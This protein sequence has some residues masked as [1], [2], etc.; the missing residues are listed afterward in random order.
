MSS[1]I[2]DEGHSYEALRKC[3][4]A[5]IEEN[6]MCTSQDIKTPLARLENVS[7]RYS[8]VSALEGLNLSVHAGEIL[9]LLGPNGAGKTT[10]VSLLLNLIAADSGTVSLFGQDPQELSARQRIGVMLQSAE[11]PETLRVS[12]LL[13]LT[14]SYYP[15]KRALTEVC[16][17]AGIADLLPRFY[18]K[19]SGGQQRRVQFALAIC[20]KVEILFLDE[21]TVG[22]DIEAR[23]ALWASLRKLI[24]EG[25]AIV[26][27]THYLEEA[28]ALADRVIVIA[29]GAVIA[30]GSVDDIRARVSQRRIRCVSA[31]DIEE[32]KLWPA[33][34]SV[35]RDGETLHIQT[36]DAEAVARRLLNA[37]H[38]LQQ[39]EIKRA[40][41]AEAFVELTN[42][43]LTK[44]QV[45]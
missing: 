39:L 28:E 17:M 21:P 6:T 27:T 8:K 44:E 16:E 23:A 24:L 40:G 14:Q 22:L 4:L 42:V 29:Q 32:I 11:L 37:D 20:A 26:L 19:L 10:A 30:E 15:Q 9:A 35:S 33:I 3:T 25:C 12:E 36:Q 43:E 2:A 18:G 1:D 34:D 13:A 41:L 38:S 5:S 31:L 7:K 45:Q